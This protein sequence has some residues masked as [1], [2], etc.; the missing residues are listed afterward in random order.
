MSENQT[1]GVTGNVIDPGGVNHPAHY[2]NH[3]SGIEV[4][5]INEV[6]SGNI[7]AAFKYVA[8]RGEKGDAIKDLKKAEWYVRREIARLSK[9][10]MR[11]Q[12]TRLANPELSEYA[13]KLMITWLAH[14]LNANAKRFYQLVARSITVDRYILGL[15]TCLPH[16]HALVKQHQQG[17]TE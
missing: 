16:I 3:P 17:A 4:I 8:R 1:V 15:E 6:L 14:E 2:Q 9:V 11:L 13:E 7:A 5:E 12:S 10:A